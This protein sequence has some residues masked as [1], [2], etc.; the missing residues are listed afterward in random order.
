MKTMYDLNFRLNEHKT[1]DISE[2]VHL[3]E[4]LPRCDND[5]DNDNAV[6]KCNNLL[7]EK[8]PGL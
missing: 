5:N 4:N 7:Y 8:T 6:T 3:F 1:I 2:N